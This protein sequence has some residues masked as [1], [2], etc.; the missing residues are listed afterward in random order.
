MVMV[1]VMVIF[2]VFQLEQ[3]RRRWSA[4]GGAQKCS[5]DDGTFGQRHR[6]CVWLIFYVYN[7][8]EF[9]VCG[10]SYYLI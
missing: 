1:M 10:V 6:M 3:M 7:R 5:E 4:L 9:P 8:V 2:F